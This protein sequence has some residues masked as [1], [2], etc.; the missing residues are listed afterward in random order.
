LSAAYLPRA[1]ARCWKFL[2]PRVSDRW[3]TVLRC[4][5]G[6]QLI[7]YCIS[8]GRGWSGQLTA[9]GGPLNHS[10]AGALLAGQGALIPHTGWITAAAERIGVSESTTLTSLWLLLLGCAFLLLLGLFLRPAAIVAWLIHLAAVK[11][12]TM[13]SYGVDNF[14]TIGLFYLMLSPLPDRLAADARWRRQRP[15][16][17]RLHGFHRRILQ[18]HLCLIY[19]FAGLTKLVSPAWW[20]GESVWRAFTRTPFD[21][22]PRDWLAAS[23]TLLVVLGL[24]TFTVELGYPVLIW[25]AR[26]RLIWFTAILALHLGIALTMGLFL[27]GSIMIILNAAAFGTDLTL[28]LHRPIDAREQIRS[29]SNDAL[30]IISCVPNSPLRAPCRPS[31]RQN[32]R[33][34][35]RMFC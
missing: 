19:F 17:L 28:P 12:G 20:N 30:L 34:R 33:R 14:T 9:R 8:T 22:L 35:S 23:P 2:F 21:I 15:K 10:L 27:F 29:T 26:T 13:T 25:P 24:C 1:R 16:S 18:L 4:G 7:L 31:Q 5:L 11:A 6:L 32:S 3:L